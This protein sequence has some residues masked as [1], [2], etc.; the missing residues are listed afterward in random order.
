VGREQRSSAPLPALFSRAGAQGLLD[1][2]GNV[3]EWTSGW[4]FPADLLDG[5]YGL[6]AYPSKTD[7]RGVERAV[8]GG[9][10]ANEMRSSLVW[11]RGSHPPAWCTPFTGFRVALIPVE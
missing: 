3:W 1:M 11:E 5:S 8:R 9:S 7:Y 6:A 10:W 4:Y 2:T